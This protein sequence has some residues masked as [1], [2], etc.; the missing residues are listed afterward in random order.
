MPERAG[1]EAE[2]NLWTNRMA[3]WRVV[4]D[5]GNTQLFVSA[6]SNTK[7]VRALLM[8]TMRSALRLVYSYVPWHDHPWHAMVDGHS[9]KQT[10]AASDSLGM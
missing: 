3:V 10:I 5:G 4:T 8:D 2:M 6:G 9:A 7:C 1:D